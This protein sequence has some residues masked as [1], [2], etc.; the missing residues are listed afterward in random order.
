MHMA[1]HVTAIHSTDF[2]N[3]HGHSFVALGKRGKCVMQ[4]VKCEIYN[5]ES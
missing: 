1:G 4:K 5:V 2:V 3:T